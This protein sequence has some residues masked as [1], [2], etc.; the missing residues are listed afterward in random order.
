ML[1][2]QPIK[3]VDSISLTDVPHGAL[4]FTKGNARF[5]IALADK[6]AA[7][8]HRDH[9]VSAALEDVVELLAGP[10]AELRFRGQSENAR[11]LNAHR[12]AKMS[13]EAGFGLA[14][15][16]DFGKVALRLQWVDP[17]N[18]AEAFVERWN[19]SEA[20]WPAAGLADTEI[21][22]FRLPQLLV[23]SR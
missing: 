11:L 4:G 22:S 18:V 15:G 9:L 17:L 7:L 2:S 23:R 21:S 13:D 3:W 10:I 5:Q 19:A 8:G 1:A 14:E 20:I 12:W 16:D 6:L